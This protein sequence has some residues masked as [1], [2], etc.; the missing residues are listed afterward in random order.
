MLIQLQTMGGFAPSLTG[1]KR[2]I[3]SNRLAAAEAA[4]L[5]TLVDHAM[6]ETPPPRNPKARDVMAYEI[7]I[8]CDEQQHLIVAF[9]GGITPAVGQLISFVRRLAKRD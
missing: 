9:D 2:T 7:H 8:E 3:D 6:A 5:Q 1:D 4:E